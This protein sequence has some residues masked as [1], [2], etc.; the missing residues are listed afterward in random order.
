MAALSPILFAPILPQ[1][2]KPLMVLLPGLDGTGQLFGPQVGRLASHFDLRCLRIPEANRQ[3]WQSLAD[4]VAGLIR[5]EQLTRAIYL[6]G[7]SYGGCL[8]LKIALS[9]PGLVDRLVL[10]NPAS[11]LRRQFWSSLMMQASRYVPAWMYGL[12]GSVALT[13]LANFDRIRG[14][15]QRRFIETVRP[16]S[17]DCVAWRLAMLY[18]FAVAPEAL[19]DLTIPT[20]LIASDRDRLLPSV[21]EAQRLQTLIPQSLLYRLPESGHVC[22]IEEEVNLTQCLKMLD[23]LPEASLTKV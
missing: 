23:F 20:A 16:I 17:Q 9:Q 10:I 8:A 18:Q 12:S 7:E 11:S 15:W 4:R 5:D 3:D 22:L 1:P 13:L 21:Q 19:E 14:D 2:E 6:C